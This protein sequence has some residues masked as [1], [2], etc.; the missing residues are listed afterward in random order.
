MMNKN[1]RKL[2]MNELEQ[3]AGGVRVRVL[4]KN[5]DDPYYSGAV[6]FRIS[7]ARSII[8]SFQLSSSASS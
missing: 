4:C 5:T 3:V 6:L 2:D 7:S 1:Y 8:F